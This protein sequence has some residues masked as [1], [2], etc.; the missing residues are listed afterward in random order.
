M[1]RLTQTKTIVKLIRQCVV[2]HRGIA[3]ITSAE[4]EL[5]RPELEESLIVL[6]SHED[7]YDEI[8]LYVGWKDNSCYVEY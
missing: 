2:G 7:I 6:E 8:I 1:L 3:G 4:I 5:Y